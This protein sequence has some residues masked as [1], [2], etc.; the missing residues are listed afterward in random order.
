MLGTYASFAAIL[1]ASGCV[2]Q[3]VFR[4]CGR[5]K[6]SWLA[7]AVGLAA[8]TAVA[9]GTVRLPGDG[10]AAAIAVGVLVVASVAFLLGRVAGLRSAVAVGLPPLI[11][12]VVAASLPFI[13]ERRFGILGTGLNP[14]MSQHLFA[15]NRLAHGEGSRLPDARDIPSARTRWSWPRQ[16]RPARAWC[17]RSTA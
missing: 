10:T 3:A 2:G 8:I 5:R 16:R 11:G 17:T 13:V 6:W 14:D 15:A 4:V 1:F 12:A 9:W 7:P